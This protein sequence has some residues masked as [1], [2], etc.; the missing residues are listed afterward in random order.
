[1][2]EVYYLN[3]SKPETLVFAVIASPVLLGLSQIDFQPFA[4]YAWLLLCVAGIMYSGP[5]ANRS[6]NLLLSWNA[7]GLMI[8]LFGGTS[9]GIL[10]TGIAITFLGFR[11]V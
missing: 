4:I 7:I 3:D 5:F 8:C 6:R 10:I 9:V 1:M 2:Q 11:Q